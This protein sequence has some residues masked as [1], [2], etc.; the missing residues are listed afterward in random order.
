V[1]EDFL[2]FPMLIFLFICE[3]Y[4]VFEETKCYEIGYLEYLLECKYKYDLKLKTL[5]CKC[6]TTDDVN[7]FNCSG[8]SISYG[9][10]VYIDN[11]MNKYLK[12]AGN[13]NNTSRPQKT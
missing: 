10:Q 1:P 6:K 5:N 2:T 12:I 11:K 3:Q 7:S 13:I 4:R 9:K 8:Y